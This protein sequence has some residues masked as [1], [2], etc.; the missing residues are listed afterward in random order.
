MSQL[1]TPPHP[2]PFSGQQPFRAQSVASDQCSYC[3]LTGHW[4]RNC[5]RYANDLRGRGQ[6]SVGFQ[7]A[8]PESAK[9]GAA[10]QLASG[11][12]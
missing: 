8:A 7:K 2:L 5:I 6:K 11:F 3:G 9:P 1:P 10:G 4:K 12:A